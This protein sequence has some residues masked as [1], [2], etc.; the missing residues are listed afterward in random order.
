MAKITAYG[1]VEVDRIRLQFPGSQF[2]LTFLL[3]SDGM[4]LRKT[5]GVNVWRY[6]T[7]LGGEKFDSFEAMKARLFLLGYEE[8]E[9][10][11][12][13]GQ[14]EPMTDAC[15]D[16]TSLPT[17][18]SDA[19]KAAPTL[20]A[21]TDA[22]GT[23][24]VPTTH[25]SAQSATPNDGSPSF[26]ETVTAF[27]ADITTPATWKEFTKLSDSMERAILAASLRYRSLT[28]INA[29]PRSSSDQRWAAA[30]AFR[31][32]ESEAAQILQRLLEAANRIPTEVIN[33][34]GVR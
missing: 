1:C 27:V 10:S 23:N 24:P 30:Q 31:T 4:V 19:A 25:E 28:E 12:K 13:R 29:D 33:E 2:V 9:D 6:D 26:E 14:T 15:E 17:A 22:T 7:V 16:T 8:V 11:L 18:G 21:S 32:A 20:D 5:D 3:R 34:R